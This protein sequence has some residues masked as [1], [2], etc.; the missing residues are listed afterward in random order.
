MLHEAKIEIERLARVTP[1]EK[2]TSAEV[3]RLLSDLAAHRMT[4]RP[5][6]DEA[7]WR[8]GL[9]GVRGGSLSFASGFHDKRWTAFAHIVSTWTG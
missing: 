9:S 5:G 1:A 3:D 7:K 2:E 4:W 8:E 6:T